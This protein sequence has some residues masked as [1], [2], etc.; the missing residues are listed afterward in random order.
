MVLAIS[1]HQV[2]WF[3]FRL[4]ILNL[5]SVFCVYKMLFNTDLSMEKLLISQEG[6]RN[7]CKNTVYR[8]AKNNWM[9]EN[10]GEN[11]FTEIFSLLCSLLL[12]RG[13]ICTNR[14][15]ATLEGV[16][17]KQRD[18]WSKILT[19]AYLTD[20]LSWVL[21]PLFLTMKIYIQIHMKV[22]PCLGIWGLGRSWA[23]LVSL[24]PRRSCRGV[25]FCLL[26]PR[27]I[28]EDK[29]ICLCKDLN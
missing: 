6:V 26:P 4:L 19:P 3:N 5:S 21:V 25:S 23:E 18:F 16:R 28:L 12:P 29:L 2:W 22:L 9:G 24:H 17:E 1:N 11:R 27:G 7:K 8:L 14:R 13:K 20:P 10:I 15:Y